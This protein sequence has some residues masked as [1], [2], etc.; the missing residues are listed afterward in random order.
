M[1][2]WSLK[3]TCPNLTCFSL[4]P[5]KSSGP[6]P[7]HRRGPTAEGPP[8]ASPSPRRPCRSEGASERFEMSMSGL[9]SRP[10][11]VRFCRTRFPSRAETKASSVTRSCDGSMLQGSSHTQTS[12]T[13]PVFLPWASR[14]F[15]NAPT[16]V[17]ECEDKQR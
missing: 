17:Q 7:F 12:L 10:Q 11:Q 14:S 4:T 2:S 5:C 15:R 3:L 16:I 1:T 8:H 6:C 13:N 9:A